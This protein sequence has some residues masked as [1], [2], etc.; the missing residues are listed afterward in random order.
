MQR[1]S[2]AGTRIALVLLVAVVDVG[3]GIIVVLV[4]VLVL[5][6]ILV[7]MVVV[8]AD[9]DTV[10][11]NVPRRRPNVDGTL[12]RPRKIVFFFLPHSLS[13]DA[14]RRGAKCWITIWRKK[15]RGS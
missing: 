11:Y 1:N 5:G 12:S 6:V 7:V 14:A 2:F 13:P 8:V 15:H 3:V 10:L 9:V 4:L